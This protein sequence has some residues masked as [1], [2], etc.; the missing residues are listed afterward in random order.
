LNESTEPTEHTEQTEPIETPEDPLKADFL[1]VRNELM[2]ELKDFV[3]S[4]QKEV[5]KIK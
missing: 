2:E 5:N 1:K 4:L 3:P